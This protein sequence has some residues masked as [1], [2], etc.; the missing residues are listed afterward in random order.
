MELLL[1]F[2]ATFD[3]GDTAL[4]GWNATADACSWPGQNQLF[5]SIPKLTLH[6]NLTYLGLVSNKLEGTLPSMSS[7][8]S[9]LTVG[10][11]PGN[12]LLCVEDK[13]LQ[14]VA[15]VGQGSFGSVY[16]AKWHHETPVAV[17]LLYDPANLAHAAVGAAGPALSL[18][19]PVFQDLQ[20]EAGMLASLRHPNI[21]SFYGVCPSPPALV[22][23][24][25]DRGS[26]YDVLRIARASPEKAAELTFTRRLAMALD[27]AKGMVYLHSHEPPILHR[28]LKSP[29]LCVTANWEVKVCDFNLSKFIEAQ[30]AA[31]STPSTTATNA[32]WLAPEILQCQGATFA[33]I[34]KEVSEG[35]RP[36]IPPREAL[37]GDG[38]SFPGI[39]G[40]ITLMT[41][42]WHA[43]PDER[44]TFAEIVR[45][46]RL[47][48]MAD[49]YGV[50]GLAIEAAKQLWA[51]VEAFREIGEGVPDLFWSVQNKSEQIGAAL[52]LRL[53]SPDGSLRG[54]GAIER[55]RAALEEARDL[56]FEVVLASR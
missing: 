26:L 47:V 34:V 41:R 22:T 13:D 24:Y 44:P 36:P 56:L 52:Q 8:A 50:A 46:L 17:K 3:N 21:V 5:G 2:K 51:M 27:A 9:I 54:D 4:S 43:L 49:P 11:K 16:S 10:V 15:K 55:A 48:I 29:N 14:M 40:Y 23:E 19:N 31:G 12:Q 45:E 7:G 25:C 33:T 38:A 39:D 28:D 30:Q 1:A 53:F 35:G 6:D 20:K 37:P 18:S 32:R 42:C